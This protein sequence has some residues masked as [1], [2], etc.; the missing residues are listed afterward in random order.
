MITANEVKKELIGLS[1]Q[2]RAKTLQRFFK[3]GK[4]EYG[5][6]DKFLGIVVP[7]IRKVVKKY[8][9]LSFD[10]IDE[11]IGD[12]FHE[13]RMVGLL[14]LINEFKK[15]ESDEQT[16][17]FNKYIEHLDLGHINNW[18]LVDVTSENVIGEYLLNRPRD[19]IYKLADI[20]DLWHRRAAILATFCFIKNGDNRDIIRLS[21]KLI[22]DK[23][24]LIQKAVGWM[25]REVGKRCDE[26]ILRDFLDKNYRKMPR[27]MLRYAIERLPEIDRKYYL[28]K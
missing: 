28:A 1:N 9:K 26:K 19:F 20:P 22:D 23:R 24:D 14:I 11:L 16:I 8:S 5:E 12:E 10:Q 6:S 13:I 17:I 3:T 7:N 21:Q 4:G 27:T 2:E 18:D 25:L 15:K